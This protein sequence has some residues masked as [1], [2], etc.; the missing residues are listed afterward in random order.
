MSPTPRA[1]PRPRARHPAGC[2]SAGRA[3]TSPSGRRVSDDRCAERPAGRGRRLAPVSDSTISRITPL[4]TTTSASSASLG[5]EAVEA[6]LRR[7]PRKS[8]RGSPPGY[9]K[10]G[11]RFCHSSKS[12]GSRASI[13]AVRQALPA[14]EVDLAEVGV[15]AHRGGRPP[16]MRG[17]APRA[18]QRARDDEVGPC[19]V[20]AATRAHLRAAF[21]GELDVRCCRGSGCSTRRSV[22]PWRTSTRRRSLAMGPPEARRPEDR[23]RARGRQSR[24]RRLASAATAPPV[25]V[26]GDHARHGIDS[27]RSRCFSA[28]RRRRSGWRCESGDAGRRGAGRARDRAHAEHRHGP[29]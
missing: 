17:G 7:A 3:A 12:T 29:A 18:A 1:A 21:V 8:A 11:A 5:E 4:W 19:R 9:S 14:P 2:S 16:T 28:P 15:E 23:E 24:P 13:S 6:A 20:R 10:P 25:E 26:E 27:A 22:S